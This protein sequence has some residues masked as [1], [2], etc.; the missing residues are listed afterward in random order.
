MVGA[1]QLGGEGG[2]GM[3]MAYGTRR[4]LGRGW[5][6]GRVGCSTEMEGF[7]LG[8]AGSWVQDGE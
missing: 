6:W 1:G 8:R 4:A 2:E 3:E 7:G 5:A